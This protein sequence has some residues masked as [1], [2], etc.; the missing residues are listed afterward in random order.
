[1]PDARPA[2]DDNSQRECRA[3]SSVAAL[4]LR[5]RR[6]GVDAPKYLKLSQ[7][8]HPNSLLLFLDPAFDVP[9][10]Y[11]HLF[12]HAHNMPSATVTVCMNAFER[13]S[14]AA[15]RAAR[16]NT[17]ALGHYIAA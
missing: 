15:A 2:D 5:M 3:A 7:P 12:P 6:D 1:M 17:H 10:S 13:V 16:G 4:K 8:R 14:S 9:Q 11:L